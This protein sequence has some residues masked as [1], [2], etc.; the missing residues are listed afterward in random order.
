MEIYENLS[1]ESLPNE[2]WRD[3]IGYEGL[4]KV[5]NLG[6]VKS[7]PRLHK[8]VHGEY[9]SK[10]KILSPRNVGKD[11]EYTAIVLYNNGNKKQCRIH[12]L[13]A[14]AFIPNPKGYKEVN[15]IDE[16]KRNNT[17]SNL[18]WCSRSYNVN[19]GRRIKK[20]SAHLH[21]EV[22]AFTIQGLFVARFKSIKDA[23]IWAGVGGSN[24]SR[25]IKTNMLSG[26][27]KW[28]FKNDAK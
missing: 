18:E 4:Y 3:V 22:F 23:A 9:L 19:Y 7:L 1:I 15:H 20:Q 6:R 21:K 28:S 26:G 10:E 17:A 14:E 27:Y 13:V 11:R 25:A 5:S 8:Y 16:N 12:R 2:E 24:I